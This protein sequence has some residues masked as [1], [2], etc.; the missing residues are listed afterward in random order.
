MCFSALCFTKCVESF[1][2]LLLQLI[3]IDPNNDGLPSIQS[4]RTSSQHSP[5]PPGTVI[6]YIGKRTSGDFQKLCPEDHDSVFVDV[7]ESLPA[8]PDRPEGIAFRLFALAQL[9][10]KWTTL[11][12]RCIITS[13]NPPIYQIQ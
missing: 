1:A 2:R 5:K 9:A 7:L 12:R 11:L 3:K 8:D 6:F 10:S 13:S 4:A